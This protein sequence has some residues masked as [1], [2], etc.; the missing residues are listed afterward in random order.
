[1]QH[2]QWIFGIYDRSKHIGI[3]QFVQKRTARVL[4]PLIKA[5]VAHGTTIYSDGWAAYRQLS[6]R[7]YQHDVVLHEE[8]FVDPITGLHINGMAAYW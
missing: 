7:G 4:L 1:M 6:A 8:N 2:N 3:I 5:H